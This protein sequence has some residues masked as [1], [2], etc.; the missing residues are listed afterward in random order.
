MKSSATR[1]ASGDGK[2]SE[3]ALFGTKRLERSVLSQQVSRVVMKG[4]LDGRLQPGDRLVENDLANL[5]GVSR[6]PIREALAELAQS[7]V[8]VRE[9]GKGSRIRRWTKQDLKDLFGVRSVLEGFAARLAA[10]RIDEKSRK[11]FEKIIAR[12]R[13]AGG[14]NDFATMIELDLEFH[15]LLW[16]LAGNALLE[17]VL[18]GL[19]Q[20]FRL[21]L[22][23]NWK[24]HGG[25]SKVAD[26]HVR[27]LDALLLHDPAEAE[28]AIQHHVVVEEMVTAPEGRQPEP[29][30]P[31]RSK[32]AAVA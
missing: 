15:L 14:R 5:L 20:Q 7:G 10:G 25:L 26:N 27:L 21:F 18:E 29:E 23:M 8:V 19:S 31:R 9:M 2:G 3:A 22:T 24:F 4:L 6:S 16:R 17:Q 32:R 11:A 28:K 30:R 12:M 1:S 13:A